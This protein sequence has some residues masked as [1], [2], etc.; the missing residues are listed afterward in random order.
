MRYNDCPT[1]ESNDDGNSNFLQDGSAIFFTAVPL[2]Q[3]TR[4]ILMSDLCQH[5]PQRPAP[6]SDPTVNA[7]TTSNTFSHLTYSHA[8]VQF[9][10]RQRS[11][12]QKHT[13]QP[14]RSHRADFIRHEEE[15]QGAARICGGREES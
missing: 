5:Q 4:D 13:H 14:P 8:H 12:R 6:E 7:N 1:T 10:P 15:W 3:R 2:S 9:H 11:L